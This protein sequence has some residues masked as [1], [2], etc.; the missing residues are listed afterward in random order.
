MAETRSPFDLSGLTALVTGASRGIGAGCA[1]ALAKSGADLVLAAR[2]A[3]DLETIADE[4]RQLG[5][6]VN[7][8]AGDVTD[9]TA[10]QAAI[11]AA[12][13]IHVLVNNAGTNIPG[14]FVD[15]TPEHFDSIMDINVR[16]AFFIAQ[17]VSAR[18]IE[19]NIKGSIIHMSSQMGHV[20]AVNRTVYCTSKHAVE[21]LTKAMAIELAPHSIRVNSVAPTFIE[22]PMTKPFLDD[23]AF[24]QSVL[25]QIPLGNVGQIEDVTGAVVYLA[26]PASRMVTGSCLKVDGGWTAR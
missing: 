14:P 8:I 1:I 25:A 5:R 7:A 10:M 20:G 18:M 19:Q 24:R 11:S 12:P 9:G 4:I 15:V 22:T 2:N 26:S 3:N 23:D 21:G 17:A 13:P 6:S 16:A